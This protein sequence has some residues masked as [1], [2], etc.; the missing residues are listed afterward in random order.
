V[1]PKR[2][3]P[4]WS[5]SPV[6]TPAPAH[7][8]GSPVLNCQFTLLDSPGVEHYYIFEAVKQLVRL[9]HYFIWKGIRYD[10]DKPDEPEKIQYGQKTLRGSG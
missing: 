6:S 1:T 2:P 8:P 10:Y 3:F 9:S 5:G 7:V 4:R